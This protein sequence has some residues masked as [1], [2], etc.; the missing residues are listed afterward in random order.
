MFQIIFKN[1]AIFLA[2]LIQVYIFCSGIF[3][4]FLSFSAIIIKKRPKK[5][6]K[7]NKFAV[8]IIACNEEKVIRFSIDSLKKMNYPKDKFSIYV[9]G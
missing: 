5:L 9:G 8:F 6:L 1:I 4:L 3:Y 2:N 7:N